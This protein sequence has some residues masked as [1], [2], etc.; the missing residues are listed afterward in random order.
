M[1]DIQKMHG[2]FSKPIITGDSVVLEGQ[3]PVSE[4]RDYANEVRSY[5]HGEGQ[6]EYSVAE[7]RPC[8]NE[9]EIIKQAAYNPVADLANTPNSVFCYHGAGHTV[10]WDQVPLAA[11]FP[12]QYPLD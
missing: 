12:Y 2:E 7:Y 9:A 1:T 5:S 3:A 4:M 10:T 6:L 8:H 11:Q